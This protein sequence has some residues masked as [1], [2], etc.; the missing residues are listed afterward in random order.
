MPK[1]SVLYAFMTEANPEGIPGFIDTVVIPASRDELETK[2]RAQANCPDAEVVFIP[3]SEWLPP[4]LKSVDQQELM[5]KFP[6]IMVKVS[7]HLDKLG[8][9][10]MDPG[11][12]IR[13]GIVMPNPVSGRVFFVY[14]I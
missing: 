6:Q 7:M 12:M 11:E 10:E 1:E 14:K 9:P 2:I 4:Y 5:A 8:V 13:N 3:P